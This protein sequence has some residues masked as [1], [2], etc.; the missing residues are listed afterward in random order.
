[1]SRSK[2]TISISNSS[3]GHNK[4]MVKNLKS[5]NIVVRLCITAVLSSQIGYTILEKKNTDRINF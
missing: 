3:L 4:K 1:M 5:L 2:F